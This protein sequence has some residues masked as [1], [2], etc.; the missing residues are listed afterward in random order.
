MVAV[1]LSELGFAGALAV[2]PGSLLPGSPVNHPTR[3]HLHNA[4]TAITNVDT[5]TGECRCLS[6]L[7]LP[8]N[9]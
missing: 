5:K 9:R 4:Q 8:P 6:P 1:F 2:I 3:H 7:P